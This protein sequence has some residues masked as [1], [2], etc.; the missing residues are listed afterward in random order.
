M[1][2]QSRHR[3]VNQRIANTFN[4][5]ITEVETFMRAD[6]NFA[7][8]NAFLAAESSKRLFVYYQSPDVQTE[9]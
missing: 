6:E 8:L 3:W 4:L 5:D 1:A 9:V 7:I 2:F